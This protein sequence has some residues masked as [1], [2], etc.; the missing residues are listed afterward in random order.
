VAALGFRDRQLHR[1]AFEVRPHVN[2]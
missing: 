1:L 2:P